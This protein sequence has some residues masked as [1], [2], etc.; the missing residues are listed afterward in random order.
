[1]QCT[2]E[3][4][5]ELSHRIPSRAERAGELAE[6]GWDDSHARSRGAPF[7]LFQLARQWL[8]QGRAAAGDAAADDH[9]L[10]VGHV[11]QRRD[12]A[13]EQADGAEPGAGRVG[14]AFKGGGD[15]LMS[16]AEAAVAPPGECAIADRVFQAA[17]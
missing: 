6:R 7:E 17:G 5:Y 3:S 14:V 15:Q 8:E 4:L 11:D 9:D 2:C 12:A 10:R 16:R 13:R 1:M